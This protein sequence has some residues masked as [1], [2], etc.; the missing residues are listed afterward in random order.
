M[1]AVTVPL[2]DAVS[3]GGLALGV[4]DGRGVGRGDAVAVEIGEAAS[5]AVAATVTEV[6]TASD[7]DCLREAWL[8]PPEWTREDV[9]CFPGSM[10]GPWAKFVRDPNAK[11]VGTVRYVRRLPA[12][13]KAV[14]ALG[15]RTLTRLYNDNPTWLQ[16][17]HRA[18]DAAVFAAYGWPI[19][20][21]DEAL[22]GRLLALNA[23][24]AAAGQ[25]SLRVRRRVK[26]R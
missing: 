15:K 13:A 25:Q 23:A 16:E 9:L 5:G 18:L 11:G 24:Q 4:A 20:L 12:D 7:L 8:N 1:S 3:L 17:A 14:A 26:A 22:L 21:D 10:H 19:D 6:C 2:G